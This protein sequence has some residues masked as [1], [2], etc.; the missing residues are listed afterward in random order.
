MKVLWIYDKEF[1]YSLSTTARVQMAKCIQA[2]H[3]IFFLAAYRNDRVQF[4]ELDNE[5]M[6]LESIKITFI[7]RF[8]FYYSQVRNLDDI[9]GKC[10]PNVLILNTDNLLL[11]RKT[12]K[13]REKYHYRIFL[14]IRTLPVGTNR[15]R[16]AIEK[17]LFGKKLQMA[18]RKF[19]G[20][21]YI[22]DEMRRYCSEK[23]S[24]PEHPSAVWS[25]GVDVEHFRSM[26][27]Q[28][29][30][31]FFRLLY[32]GAVANNRGLQNVVKALSLMKDREIKLTILGKGTGVEEIRGL[33][34]KL[35]L[36]EKVELLTP[37]PYED[38]P[39]YINRADAGILPFPDWP[40]WNTSSPIKLFEYLACCKPVIVTRIPAHT[41]VLNGKGFAFWAERSTP[42]SIAGAIE[43]AY[44][45]RS[46][47]RGLGIE[48]REFVLENYTW[49]K[50]AQKLERFIIGGEC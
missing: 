40:G 44:S 9:V 48:A 39:D 31:S 13:L 26:E 34:E 38:V 17:Y 41:S 49:E 21:T 30:E 2:K 20:I 4:P 45:R 47:L 15:L 27:G 11:I 5:I 28:R 37:V 46:E 3:P 12:I 1:D 16:N 6:Y 8:S 29:K 35:N 14:D 10:S 25:S 43:E 50:Q 18:S 24:L 23:H 36:E 42:E 19:D 32:H 7:K 33:R 22:T